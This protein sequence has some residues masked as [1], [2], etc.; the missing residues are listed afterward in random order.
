MN[1]FHKTANFIFKT[2]KNK[3]ELLDQKIF[4]LMI[5]LSIQAILLGF[6]T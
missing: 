1:N 4:A 5:F 6:W 3:T 2:E